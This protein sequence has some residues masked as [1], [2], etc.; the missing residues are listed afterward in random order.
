MKTF[1]LPKTV[2][3][4]ISNFFIG[5]FAM[6]KFYEF[7]LFVSE[8]LTFMYFR[9]I[10][11][12][13]FLI[14]LPHNADY[15]VFLILHPHE[16]HSLQLFAVGWACFYGIDSCS[17]YIAVAENICKADNIFLQWIISPCE[18]MAEV[19]RKYFVLWYACRFTQLFHRFPYR[20]PVHRLTFSCYEYASRSD[21][22]F[23]YIFFEEST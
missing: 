16:S 9:G 2:R 10:I 22:L 13:E 8:T 3:P 7:V 19:V 17:I 11:Y 14:V 5:L 4:M 18:Q 21:M 6:C 12:L 15:V 1:L 20:V 23:L